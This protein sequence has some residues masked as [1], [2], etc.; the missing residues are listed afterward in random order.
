MSPSV[1]IV[2]AG[3]SG[4]A[5]AVELVHAGIAVAVYESARQPGGRA[6][7]LRIDGQWLDNGQHLLSGAY[8]ETLAL[9]GEIGVD[10]DSALLRLPLEMLV[11]GRFHLRLPRLGGAWAA[12]LALA[13]GLLGARGPGLRE[14]WAAARFMRRLKVDRYHLAYDL[15]VAQWLDAGGQ[16]GVLRRHLWESL[17]LAAL[18]TPPE[19]ASARVFANVLRDTL[20]GRREAT[21][22]LVPRVDLG[23]LMPLPAIEFVRSRGGAFHCPARVRSIACREKGFTI[24]GDGFADDFDQVIVATAPQHASALLPAAPE[25]AATAAAIRNLAYEPICTVY[26]RYPSTVRLPLPLLAVDAEHCQ[27]VFDR[28]ALGPQPGLIAHV[29]SAT[30]A[31]ADLDNAALVAALHAGLKTVIAD[32]PSPLAQRVVCERRATFSCAPGLVR[33]PNATPV[34]GL[35]LAGDYTAGDYPATIEG[36]VRSGRA[37]AKAVCNLAQAG[38][39]LK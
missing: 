6:R 20:G 10:V 12:P 34:R 33:P 36:A 18:N 27:W 7:G 22:L 11:P 23:R 21:D 30:G 26:V 25:L 1:A 35:W 14:K 38:D 4:L 16:H 8:S 13:F 15:P 3:W 37:A 32:L 5:A 39:S 31:W 17:C 28:G 29:L 24:G 9:F 19:R 2:G